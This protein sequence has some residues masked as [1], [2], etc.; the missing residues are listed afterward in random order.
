MSVSKAVDDL[1]IAFRRLPGVG[2]KSAQRMVFQLL[3]RDRDGALEIADA[4]KYA[5]E[6]V[7]H[8]EQ[9]NNFC[10]TPLCG[11]CA[12]DRRNRS[13]LC[14]VETPA[15]LTSLESTGVYDGLY[16]VLMGRISPLDGIGPKELGVEGLLRTLAANSVSEVVLGM[17]YTVEGDATAEFLSEM[18]QRKGYSA[19][20][21]ARG[22]PVGGELEYLDARTLSEAFRRRGPSIQ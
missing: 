3:A 7:R 13:I 8:C 14:V 20:W 21:L 17:N 2:P 15:D 16:Y 12:S 6:N 4:L 11:I 18:L 1:M 10:E 22:L 19:S 5:A 9:C